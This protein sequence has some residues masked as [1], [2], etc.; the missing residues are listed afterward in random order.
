MEKE[1]NLSDE[2][3]NLVEDFID[4][5]YNEFKIPKHLQ[6]TYCNMHCNL[7]ELIQEIKKK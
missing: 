6:E 5:V 3:I 2:F 7:L 4:I 1:Y